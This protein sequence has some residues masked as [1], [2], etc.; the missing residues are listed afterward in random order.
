MTANVPHWTAAEL[1][2]ISATEEVHVSSLRGDGTLSEGRTIWTVVVDGAVFIRST[3]G[4]DKPWFRA[5][6]NR[7]AGRLRVGD[8]SFDVTFH[9]ASRAGPVRD[10]GRVPPEVPP[11]PRLQHQPR[12][13]VDGNAAAAAAARLNP[14]PAH[15]HP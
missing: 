1:A 12:G 14:H 5:A 4:P 11:S 7:G 8:A 3:D 9:H 2:A 10:R 15:S 6:K 13:R